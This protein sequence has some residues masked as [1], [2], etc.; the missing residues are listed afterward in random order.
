ML[1]TQRSQH[2]GSH[3][4]AAAHTHSTQPKHH[5]TLRLC[6]QY[7]F[8]SVV[9]GWNLL[10]RERFLAAW[11]V[12]FTLPGLYLLGLLRLEGIRADEEVSLPRLLTASAFLIFALSLVPGMFGAVT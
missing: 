4:A 1:S 3:A 11:F 10:T 7:T 5:G 6:A 12:L 9:L 8:T 2:R